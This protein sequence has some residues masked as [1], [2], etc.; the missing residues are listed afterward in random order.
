MMCAIMNTLSVISANARHRPVFD[1]RIPV[2]LWPGALTLAVARGEIGPIVFNSRLT[3]PLFTR[4]PN[5]LQNTLCA[6][7]QA[8]TLRTTLLA[9]CRGRRACHAEARRRR[10]A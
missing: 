1:L 5:L 6:S 8:P 4:L 10:V 3:Q 7:E 2:M 9:N